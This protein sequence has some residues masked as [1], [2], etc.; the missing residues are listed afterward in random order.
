MVEL[1]DDVAPSRFSLGRERSSQNSSQTKESAS[2]LGSFTSRI[3]RFYSK[4]D[5]S[6][7]DNAATVAAK[8]G[9]SRAGQDKLMEA[10]V[11][12]YGPEPPLPY[13]PAQGEEGNSSMAY[14]E[15]ESAT[16]SAAEGARRRLEEIKKRLENNR[17][18]RAAEM[19][20]TRS[21]NAA[22]ADIHASELR[23]SSMLRRAE[24]K[25]THDRIKS[26]VMAKMDMNSYN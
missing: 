26:D 3:E 15:S 4:Y 8:Y 22:Q 25:Q 20:A 12:K 2:D 14:A 6:K 18:T 10:L 7:V 24:S 23:A 16:S 21:E 1:I 19:K 11:T 9:Q 17:I 5:P 13:E